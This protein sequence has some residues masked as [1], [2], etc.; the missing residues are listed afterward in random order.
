M[1]TRRKEDK[2][3]RWY[4][5]GT[6]SAMAVCFTHPLDLVKVHMQTQQKGKLSFFG[7]FADV[8][9]KQGM[10]ITLRT[11]T[12]KKENCRIYHYTEP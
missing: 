11:Q 4:F 8:I 12:F 3:S 10:Y 7:A 2:I 6:A 1:G 9:Q 5:G